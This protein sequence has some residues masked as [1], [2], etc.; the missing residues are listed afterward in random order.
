MKEVILLNIKIDINYDI[1]TIFSNL[2]IL[3]RKLISEP[4]FMML[5]LQDEFFRVVIVNETD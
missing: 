4:A 3:R 5:S 1:S 2:L